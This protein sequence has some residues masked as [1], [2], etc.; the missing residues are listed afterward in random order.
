MLAKS[1]NNLTDRPSSNLA[2]SQKVSWCH[3]CVSSQASSSED[4]STQAEEY[5]LLRAANR[6]CVVKTEVLT[7]G[8]VI[9]RVCRSVKLL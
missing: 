9:C 1:S 3:K 6:Q 8:A 7:F 4:V 5:P 2:V